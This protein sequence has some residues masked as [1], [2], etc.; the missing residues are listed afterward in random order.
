MTL[1]LV[2]ASFFSMA[3]A[4]TAPAATPARAYAEGQVWEYRTRPQ[5]E[6][7]LL[8]IQRIED[9]GSVFHVSLVGVRLGGSPT[10]IQHLP[11]SRQ[12]LDASVTRLSDSDTPFPDVAAGYAE[13][14]RAQ[15]GVFTLTMAEIVDFVE[16]ALAGEPRA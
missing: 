8:K 13:W 14:Q 16:Q 2:L 11:V 12:T 9:A 15:G 10:E 5:D 3:G 1:L 4:Q 6:G 7:S